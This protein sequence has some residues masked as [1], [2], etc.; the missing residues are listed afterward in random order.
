LSRLEDQE[1]LHDL[2]QEELIPDGEVLT[3]WT[4]AFEAQGPQG[5]YFGYWHGPIGI[6]PW[7]SLGLHAQ[8]MNYMQAETTHAELRS[9]EV[10]E[11]PP[12]E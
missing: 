9:Y 3:T 5:L 4:I 7:R 11:D 8:A 6:P 10:P 12:E 2:L 1:R